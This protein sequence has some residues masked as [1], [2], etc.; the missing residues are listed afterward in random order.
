MI[1]GQNIVLEF[2][3][4][5]KRPTYIALTNT[6]KAPFVGLSPL[7]GGI[8]ADKLS[9]PFAFLITAII[10]SLG[11]LLLKFLVQEPRHLPP[12]QPPEYPVHHPI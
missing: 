12:Y 4:P 11:C 7:L 1:S 9:F 3:T 2:S 10:L 8:I 6:F 5:Q